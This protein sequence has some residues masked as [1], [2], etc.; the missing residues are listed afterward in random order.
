MSEDGH[1]SVPNKTL[2]WAIIGSSFVG[3]VGLM[4]PF[5]WM[6]L[7]SPLPYMSTPRR[8]VL[9]ALEEITRHRQKELRNDLLA[10]SRLLKYYDLGSGD[11]EAVLAAASLPGWDATGIELNYTLWGISN[12]RRLFQGTQQ[13]LR[14]SA[15]SYGFHRNVFSKSRFWW[16]DFWSVTIKDAD[17]VMIFGVTPLMPRIADKIQKECKPGTFILSYRFQLPIGDVISVDDGKRLEFEGNER[18]TT[19]KGGQNEG[20]DHF[21]TLVETPLQRL[22][23]SL[24][25]D[26]EEMRIY[27][28]LDGNHQNKI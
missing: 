27:K 8:K 24:V 17:T 26:I 1:T 2:A 14:L 15:P 11:G 13:L 16:A 19:G 23:A 6:Q 3:T 10:S 4:F 20:G 28:L 18:K 21:S 9:L 7:K 12:M 25:Y 5:V 22:N